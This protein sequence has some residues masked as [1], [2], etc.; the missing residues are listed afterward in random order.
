MNESSF[1]LYL[2]DTTLISPPYKTKV[3]SGVQSQK[4]D[5]ETSELDTN[6]IIE[7]QFCNKFLS[8]FLL[9]VCLYIVFE[10]FTN[11]KIISQFQHKRQPVLFATIGETQND[12]FHIIEFAMRY[13]ALDLH[14]ETICRKYS[15]VQLVEWCPYV[16]CNFFCFVFFYSGNLNEPRKKQ[17]NK[18]QRHR[19]GFQMG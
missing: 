18:K 7:S 13:F 10:C 8:L 5:E 14:F 3:S 2:S 19:K 4:G 16:T 15:A 11:T 1:Q 17:K 12:N 9:C 6:D